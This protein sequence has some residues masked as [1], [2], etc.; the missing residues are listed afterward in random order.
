MTQIAIRSSPAP[1]PLRLEMGS[2]LRLSDAE[3]LELCRRNPELRI[4]RTAEGDLIVMSPVGG[5][6]ARRNARLVAALVNWADEDST[7]VVYDSSGGFIL[8]NGAM[9]S[10]DA[11][12]VPKSRLSGLSEEQR[13]GFLPLCPDF[14]IELRSPSD[15][16]GDLRAKMEAYVAGGAGLGWLIDP[17]ERRVYVYRAGAEVEVLE[18]HRRLSASPELPGFVLDLELIWPRA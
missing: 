13:E 4:E 3:L 7:G 18:D 8:P 10:P 11:A 17:A 12:W 1:V 14:V 6:S 9:R 16:L 15:T 2:A 5:E